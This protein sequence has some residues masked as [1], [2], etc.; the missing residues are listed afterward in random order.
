MNIEEKL[1]EILCELS[2]EE[3]VEN[4]S[5]LQEDL[6]LDSLMMDP[7]KRY[8]TLGSCVVTSLGDC[9]YE[10]YQ[11]LHTDQES[12]WLQKPRT[13][14]FLAEMVEVKTL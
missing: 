8:Y 11:R 9:V 12:S 6:A 2:G 3:S 4:T 10:W 5:Q 14:L 7:L 13:Q 1:K